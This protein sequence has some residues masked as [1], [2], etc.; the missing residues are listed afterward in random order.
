MDHLIGE[1]ISERPVS[2]W[3]GRICAGNQ[4]S[5]LASPTADLEGVKKLLL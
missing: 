3:R 4:I 5:Q 2:L 1:D